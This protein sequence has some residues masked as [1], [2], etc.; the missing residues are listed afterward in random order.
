[1]EFID[2]VK[3]KELVYSHLNSIQGMLVPVLLSSL[4]LRHLFSYNSIT[5]IIHLMCMGFAGR[6]LAQA[7]ALNYSKIIQQAETLL[8]EIHNLGVLYYDPIPRNMT[9][10]KQDHSMIF[11]DFKRS[12]LQSQH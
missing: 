8:Q 10:N 6:T 7:H 3:N 11:I 4:W 2:R 12:T 1:M 9:W 5:K